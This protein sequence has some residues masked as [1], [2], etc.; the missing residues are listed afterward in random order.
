[1]PQTRAATHALALLASLAAVQA[2]ALAQDAAP[3]DNTRDDAPPAEVVK[4]APA[5]PTVSL[6]L[7]GSLH[8]GADTD[9]GDGDLSLARAGALLEAAFPLGERRSLAVGLGI[10]RSW[11]DFDNAASLDP[12]GD[13][14]GDVTDTEL[15]LR[16]TAPLNADTSWFLLGAI[17]LAAEDGADLSD[18]VVYTG[19][20]GFI[21][22]ASE[23][24]SWGLGVV[25]RSRLEDDPLV[26]PI[27]QIRWSIDERWTLES[28]R[29]GLR[30]GYA[31][32]DT[33]TYG[34]QGEYLS[35]SFRLDEDG[36]IPDGMATDRRV[37]VSVFAEYQPSKAVSIGAAIGASVY[38]NIELLDA[39]GDDLADDDLDPALF[40]SI[41]ARIAF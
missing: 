17:G 1:M 20:G 39:D 38:S 34:V 5:G 22:K 15:T 32:S 12:G 30:L 26:V 27:P 6:R 13:P 33:L 4:P 29:A 3:A 24:F 40:L 31:H 14:F 9:T 16:Y 28:R 36:P 19:G 18:S 21:T 11:Y 25:V 2:P 10:E 7:S 41:N 37:P 8:A 23:S 35:R